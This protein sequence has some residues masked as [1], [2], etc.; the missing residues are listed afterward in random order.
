MI[1]IDQ[2]GKFWNQYNIRPHQIDSLVFGFARSFEKKI[3]M[4]VKQFCVLSINK[5]CYE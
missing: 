5:I 4:K 3:E 2:N 1:V